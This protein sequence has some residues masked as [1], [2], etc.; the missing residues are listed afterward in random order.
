[1]KGSLGKEYL[2]Q[3]RLNLLIV[4]PHADLSMK[5]YGA[6]L[7]KM[8]QNASHGEKLLRQA[9]ITSFL[10]LIGLHLQQL[11]CDFE[12]KNLFYTDSL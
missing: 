7:K 2:K 10:R 8:L 12:K 1:M 6:L 4:S 3:K 11:P 9:A 5:H